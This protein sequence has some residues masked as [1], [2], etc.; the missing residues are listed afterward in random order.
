MAAR[1]VDLRDDAAVR[2]AVERIGA[3]DILVNNAG[4]GQSTPGARGRLAAG[5]ARE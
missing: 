1:E 5:D 4:H 3:V 2:V